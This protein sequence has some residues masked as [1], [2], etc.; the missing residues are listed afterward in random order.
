[1]NSTHHRLNEA[2]II[3]YHGNDW[4]GVPARQ[5]YL[6][7]AMAKYSHVYYLDK[8]RDLPGRVTWRK[9]GDNITVIRG[10]ARLAIGLDA[11]R[12]G[13][14]MKWHAP[15]VLRE[16][17]Q[18]FSKVLLWTAENCLRV[19]RFIPH[20]FLVFDCIDPAFDESPAA[21]A[22]FHERENDVLRAADVVF[23]SAELLEERC[24]EQ[25]SNVTLLN[26]ACEPAEYAT[27]LLTAAQRPSW[28]PSTGHPVAA[29]LGSMDWRFDVEAMQSACELN[30][31]VH[32]ILAGNIYAEPVPKLLELLQR[33]NVTAP[34][35]V[36]VEDGR[37]LLANCKIGLIP[38]TPGSMNDAVNPVKMYTYAL[39]GKPVLGTAIRE[40]VARP[41]IVQIA[42][43]AGEF[44]R[45]I[46]QTLTLSDDRE[47]QIRLGEFALRNTWSH[48]ARVA[49]EVLKPMLLSSKQEIQTR[50]SQPCLAESLSK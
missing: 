24:R 46:P 31:K 41:D 27:S 1:M 42:R 29:F 23:A 50:V 37:Y 3:Y 39:L 40:L 4:D 15:W 2:C 10:L 12:L 43:T 5:R 22:A 11:R 18:R 36:S 8:G 7:E 30:P 14:L 47:Y 20:D 33:P 48:R 38:F 9:V 35:Q 21:L 44:G 19:D 13:W 17:R 25:N 16:I 28:W 49:M 45:M 34:G 32:F 26:N 6:M